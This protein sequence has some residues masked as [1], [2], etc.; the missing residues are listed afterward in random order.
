MAWSLDQ[1]DALALEVP[2]AEAEL[3]PQAID[4]E[5]FAQAFG[6]L[7]QALETER[8]SLHGILKGMPYRLEGHLWVAPV[9]N[10]AMQGQLEQNRSR[11]VEALRTATAN[12]TLQ[13]RVEVDETLAPQTT[14]KRMSLEEKRQRMLEINP[15]LAELERR[16]STTTDF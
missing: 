12:P 5:A 1:L 9:P 2:P 6:T 14:T 13:L 8:P 3:P 7:L 11:V 16:F 15:L 10:A 4:P